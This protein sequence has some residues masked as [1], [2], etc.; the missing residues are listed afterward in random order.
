MLQLQNIQKTYKVKKKMIHALNGIDYT[1]SDHG[2]YWISG[3]SGSGKSTLLHI[4]GGLEKA[5]SGTVSGT[6]S[7]DQIGI[8]FQDHNLLSDF[9]V[10]DNLAIFGSSKEDIEKTLSQLD[11]LDRM[12]VQAKYLSG[13]EK[14]RL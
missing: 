1:F 6:Y 5:S 14:Q 7:F 8:V 3:A 2:F 11:L 12:N 10:Y 9:T 13:G 4:I